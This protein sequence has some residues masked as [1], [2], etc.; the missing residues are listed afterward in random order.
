MSSSN[1]ILKC[2]QCGFI[3]SEPDWR[4]PKCYCEFDNYDFDTKQID[5]TP[6]AKEQSNEDA[7]MANVEDVSVQKK[8]LICFE[9]KVE[10][11]SSSSFGDD[12]S[13]WRY[14]NLQEVYSAVSEITHD[15][16]DDMITRDKSKADILVEICF[17]LVRVGQYQN[18]SVKAYQVYGK[19]SIKDLNNDT[20]VTSRRYTGTL[21]PD[22]IMIHK[23]LGSIYTG[24]IPFEEMKKYLNKKVLK[25]KVFHNKGIN[26]A[27]KASGCFIATA[28]YGS[29][30]AYEVN[31]LR[32]WR[33]E[34]LLKSCFGRLFVNVYYRISPPLAKIIENSGI[35]KMMARTLLKPLLAVIKRFTGQL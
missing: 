33:D 2:P 13:M 15:I 31:L 20:E 25:E 9:D 35:L 27:Q 12:A 29:C 30:M 24:S 3:M 19:I 21:P 17:G 28:A 32:T 5:G 22:E 16:P 7:P 1:K 26:S 10:P 14:E 6:K 4:C 18:T 11:T 34:S 8:K 23:K